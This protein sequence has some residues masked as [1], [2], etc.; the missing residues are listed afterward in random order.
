MNAVGKKLQNAFNNKSM[1]HINP[2][3]KENYLLV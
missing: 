3:L 2:K 1:N